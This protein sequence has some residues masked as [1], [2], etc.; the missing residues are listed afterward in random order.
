MGGRMCDRVARCLGLR[1]DRRGAVLR[2][3][4][5]FGAFVATAKAGT[6]GARA[7]PP[8]RPLSLEVWPACGR[9]LHPTAS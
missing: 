7:A 6:R 1:L 2:G 3:T 8:L 4:G 9:R 5:A